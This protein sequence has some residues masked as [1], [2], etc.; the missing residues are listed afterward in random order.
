MKMTY[1]EKMFHVCTIVWGLTFL[2]GFAYGSETNN[3]IPQKKPLSIEVQ[4]KVQS[5]NKWLQERPTAIS[6]WA[7][8]EWNETKEF[9]KKSWAN[10]K[11]QFAR[12][13]VQ[14]GNFFKALSGNKSN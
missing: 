11:E 14:V 13:K 5:I 9:Q 4:E 12:N 6:N 8:N 7:T 1:W 10:G 2:T 3:V